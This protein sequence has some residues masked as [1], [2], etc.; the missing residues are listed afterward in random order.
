MNNVETSSVDI[1]TF[2]RKIKEIL[3]LRPAIR[4]IEDTLKLGNLSSSKSL[5][6]VKVWG[7]KEIQYLKKN[8]PEKRGTVE[9]EKVNVLLSS[10]QEAIVLYPTMWYV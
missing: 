2:F 1:E 4:G 7:K 6:P 5:Y 9:S 3:K 10:Y 8:T